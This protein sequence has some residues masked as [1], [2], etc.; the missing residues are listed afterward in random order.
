MRVARAVSSAEGCAASRDKAIVH[1]ENKRLRG[2]NTVELFQ[3]RVD[4]ST[5]QVRPPKRRQARSKVVS[6]QFFQVKGVRSSE[7]NV[8]VEER[9][10]HGDL[11][12]FLI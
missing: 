2:Q 4:L 9:L 10:L 12:Y 7:R 3:E 11:E 5:G 8:A 6:L 1:E